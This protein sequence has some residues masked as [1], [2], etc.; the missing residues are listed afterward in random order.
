MP[1]TAA[2]TL[3]T[4]SA[5]SLGVFATEAG[6]SDKDSLGWDDC[7]GWESAGDICESPAESASS[8]EF[9]SSTLSMCK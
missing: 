3:V 5:T 9:A 7:W 2:V 8:P 1:V 6:F 4:D